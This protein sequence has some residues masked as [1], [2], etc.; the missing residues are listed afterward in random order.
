MTKSQHFWTTYPLLLVNLVCEQPLMPSRQKLG[1]FLL[2]KQNLFERPFQ[3]QML[4]WHQ[5]WLWFCV[6]IFLWH[7]SSKIAGPNFLIFQ[8]ISN[9]EKFIYFLSQA[10]SST[11]DTT[12]TFSCL[13]WSKT[14]K[15]Y[16]KD[17]Y[18]TKSSFCHFA[19]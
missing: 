10:W 7:K 13:S 1:L 9:L 14:C 11:I 19:C 17:S 18:Q 5:N 16:E 12:I 15:N 4:F 2:N 3:F 8:N 6:E